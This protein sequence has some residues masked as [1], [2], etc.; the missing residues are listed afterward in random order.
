M[1]TVYGGNEN[2]QIEGSASGIYGGVQD[3]GSQAGARSWGKRSGASAGYADDEHPELDEVG[4]AGRAGAHWRQGGNTGAGRTLKA[5]PGVAG[6]AHGVFAVAA[7]SAS[8]RLAALPLS[9]TM[10][11]SSVSTFIFIALTSLS[12][13]YSIFIL[14]VM[15]ASPTFSLMLSVTDLV[16]A[17]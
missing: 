16:S 8:A 7:L 13:A 17:A 15:T 14:V 10:P 3:G 11:L 6:I 9:V 5:A 1:L 2:E 12:L 4:A